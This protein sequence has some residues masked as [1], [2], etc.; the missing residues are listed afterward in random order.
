MV[1]TLDVTEQFVKILTGKGTDGSA[2]VLLGARGQWKEGIRTTALSLKRAP[3]SLGPRRGESRK[4]AGNVK[5]HLLL[6]RLG[7]RRKLKQKCCFYSSDS[8]ESSATFCGW[9][10][11]LS[12]CP[13]TTYSLEGVFHSQQILPFRSNDFYFR[14]LHPFSQCYKKCYC[15]EIFI[16]G[17]FSVLYSSEGWYMGSLSCLTPLSAVVIL[18]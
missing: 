8:L 1:G 4:E 11:Q 2:R 17:V 16:H 5:M 15:Q 10:E 9:R 6:Q 7:S 3:E 13:F 14:P 12:G 18:T